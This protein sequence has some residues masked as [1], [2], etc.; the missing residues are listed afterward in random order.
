MTITWQYVYSRKVIPLSYSNNAKCHVCSMLTRGNKLSLFAENI[1]YFLARFD[2]I[3]NNPFT[4]I[5][6]SN[7]TINIDVKSK[8]TAT[9]LY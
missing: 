5:C 1:T 9:E 2:G 6:N 3:C 7:V 4:G 8:V